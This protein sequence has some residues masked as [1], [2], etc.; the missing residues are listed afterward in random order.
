VTA[1]SDGLGR[2]VLRGLEILRA[3][4]CERS[5]LS[6]VELVRRTGLSKATVSRLT[7]TLIQTG[8]LRHASGRRGFELA[9]G[10]LGIGHAYLET[11]AL[12]REVGPHLQQ[13]AE[14]LD[15]SAALAVPDGLDMVY[16]AYRTSS[17]VATLRLGVGS[18]LPM[19]SSAIG[20]AY[21]WSLPAAE[22]RRL[23]AQ[24]RLQAGDG[25]AALAAGL[26]TS[27]AE[28][29]ATGVCC[30]ASAVLRDTFGFALPVRRGSQGTQMAMSCGRAASAP[31]L[32]AERRR[33]VP[34]LQQTAADVQRQL[35]QID[36]RP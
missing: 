15:V 23:L 2:T 12:V 13:M 9:A 22:Q 29:D 10:S 6:N 16:I 35:A 31:D 21:L 11:S 24:I 20:R 28:L 32:A 8:H 34:L 36:A 3:F 33:I 30:V 25:A 27:F 5:A 19:G 4:R 26:R 7:S 17:R 18:M 14:R 1:L